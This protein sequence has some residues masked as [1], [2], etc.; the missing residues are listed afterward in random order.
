MC[1]P[2]EDI[3][4]FNASASA[5]SEFCEWVQVGI[6]AYIPRCKYQV[7]PHSSAWFSAVCAA[8]IVYRNHF[9]QL[10]QQEKCS[11]SK[12]KFRQVSNHSESVL[13]AAKLTYVATFRRNLTLGAFGEL[14]IV[15]STKI[16]LLYLLYYTA[17]KCCVLHLI[18]Q[19]C[20][21]KAFLSSLILMTQLSL[22]L[23]SLLELIWN[24]KM[25]L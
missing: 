7:N 10:Y 15:F 22:Y 25:F 1:I 17:W 8:A 3:F 24:C 12:R 21:L 14:L 9:F 6:I 13:K 5:A 23:F 19:N 20:F 2:W 4:K 11:E 18:K 16:N